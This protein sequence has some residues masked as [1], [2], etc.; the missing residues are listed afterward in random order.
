MSN[1]TLKYYA[2][3]KEQFIG[4]TVHADMS[5]NYTDFLERVIPSGHILD[6]GC[7]SG[8][9]SLA[10]LQRGYKVTAV[11]GSPE[12][13]KYA[14]QLLNQPVRT[15]LFEDLDYEK[16]FDGIWACASLLHVPRE[17]LPNI[18]QKVQRALKPN[19]VLYLSFKYGDF[20]GERGGRFFTDMNEETLKILIES[21][22]GL[23]IEKMWLTD[24]VR[25]DRVEK[26]L[27]VVGRRDR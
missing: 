13:C 20:E 1:Y 25:V 5:A 8:R 19:G 23:T 18:M 26:W 7:G 27:N 4:S 21:V 10:F 15:L 17:Q 24:D 16:V 6:L 14:A 3:N 22:G 11:D 9:D 12:L 2:D